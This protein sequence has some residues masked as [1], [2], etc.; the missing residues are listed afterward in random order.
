MGELGIA[1]AI[2]A[3]IIIRFYIIAV[4]EMNK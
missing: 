1:I 3:I 4:T 2:L